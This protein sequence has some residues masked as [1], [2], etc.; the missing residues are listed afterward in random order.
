MS[1]LQLMKMAVTQTAGRSLLITKKFAPEILVGAGIVGVIASTVMCCKAT[2]KASLILDETK[3][4]LSK[5]HT[6][7]ATVTAEKYSEKD[8]QKDLIT[9]YTQTGVK[10][11]KTYGPAITLGLVSIGCILGGYNVLRKRNLALMAAYKA[12]EESF[13]KYRKRVIDDVGEDKDRYY[14]TGIKQEK[15][16]VTETDEDGNT[17]TT[18]KKVNVVDKYGISSYARYFNDKCLQYSKIPDYN[19]TFLKM[20]ENYANDLLQSRGHV[21]LNEIYEQ[22][23]IKHSTEGSVVGWVKGHGD[24][25]IDFGLFH[26][27]TNQNVADDIKKEREDFINGDADSVLLDFN[28]DGVIYD[29]I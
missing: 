17:K 24:D 10:F 8:Y 2:T 19:L 29:M 26:V 18:E 27:E 11:V 6:V 20:Q 7:H 21:F 5:I 22:L 16:T 15:I 4:E 1:K 28:V 14:K 12:V 13:A 23:G 3:E 25:Y 9:I